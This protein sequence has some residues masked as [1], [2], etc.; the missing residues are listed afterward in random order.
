LAIP[1]NPHNH[2]FSR[3]PNHQILASAL[4]L[5]LF[6]ALIVVLAANLRADAFFVGDPGIKLIA[7]RNA[8]AH[9]NRPLNI[10]LPLIDGQRLPYVE[11]FFEVHADHA[12]AVT[13]D[14]FPLISAPLIKCFG[15]RGA[16]V[17]PAFGFMGILAGCAWLGSALDRRRNT[18][19]VI[20][21][22]GLATPFL[23]YGLEFWEHAPGVALA[24]CAT[25]MFVM[26]RTRPDGFRAAALA[27]GSGVVFGAALLMRP[28]MI[29]AMGAVLVAS[30]W[31]DQPARRGWLLAGLAIVG[32]VL[33][34]APL[35]AYTLMHFG[36]VV[37]SHI[38]ANSAL[39]R[40]G[41][42]AERAHL[43]MQW[44]LPSGW[45]AAGPSR[46]ASFWSAAPVAV[47]ALVPLPSG[48][49]RQGRRFLWIA[50]VLTCA[51]VLLTAP[52]DGGGQWGP[53]Y[54]LFVYVPLVVL[55]ADAVDALPKRKLN[56]FALI[57]L[58]VGCVWIQ[59]SA[60]RQLRGT[61]QMYGRV[62]DFVAQ[63]VEPGGYVVTDLWW[64]DQIAAAATSQRQLVYA[65]DETTATDIMRRLNNDVVPIVTVIRSRS[66]SANVHSWTDRTCYIE[67]HRHTLEVR[68]LVAIWLHHRC[69]G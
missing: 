4:L 50:G 32:A 68:D 48:I 1:D 22:A 53:R 39:L 62:V 56:A 26:A 49:E 42:M 37:P 12:H 54:L 59:H 8:L 31:L 16:Y 57:V 20:A 11:P 40:A 18:A 41:W 2:P 38:G 15:I 66:E 61:K 33:A 27:A 29:C 25:A 6:A 7:A 44:L 9:P 63:E 64:L 47:L 34:L 24:T 10:P 21:I 14:V 51:L 67:I 45:T 19:A 23:F 30:I 28:E 43:A 3:L 13:S 46:L 17:L 5:V 69:S 60:Y 52:N 55:A 58:L 36:R 65:A 35:E